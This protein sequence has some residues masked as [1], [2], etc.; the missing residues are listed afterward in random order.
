MHQ[1]KQGLVFK[2]N[3]FLFIKY[4]QLHINIA[5]KNIKKG[6]SMNKKLKFDSLF[7]LS[8]QGLN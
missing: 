4:K 6:F 8:A 1:N 3:Y 5:T 7:P 2:R